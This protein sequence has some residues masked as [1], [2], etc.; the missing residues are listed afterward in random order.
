MVTGIDLVRAQILIA[1]GKTLVRSGGRNRKE[2]PPRLD[3]YAIQC[4]VTTE[5][6]SNNFA[7]D[8]GKI[9]SYRTGGGLVYVLTVATLIQEL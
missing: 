2:Q 1:E 9:T 4:R 8:T 5:D 6:P 7:P 3:G